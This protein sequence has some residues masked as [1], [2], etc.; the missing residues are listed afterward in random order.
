ML[1]EG[2]LS[3]HGSMLKTGV[4]TVRG[5]LQGHLPDATLWLL[6][7]KSLENVRYSNDEA[8][9]QKIQDW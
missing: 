6:L 8:N 2:R 7:V 1:Y 4:R 5:V 3:K 9:E